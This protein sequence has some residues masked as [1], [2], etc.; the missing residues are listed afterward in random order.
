MSE[1]L[2]ILTFPGVAAPGS[3]A[4]LGA[5]PGD[6][7]VSVTSIS[8]GALGMN[9]TDSFMREVQFLGQ[10]PARTDG[11]FPYII[12][13]DSR[14]LSALIF[15]ALVRKKEFDIPND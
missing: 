2:A 14:N 15:V 11:P 5:N 6:V 10:L 12:Q 7:L 8:A 13:T 1:K 4:L 3:I 9:Y